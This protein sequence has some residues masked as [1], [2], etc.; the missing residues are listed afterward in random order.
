M[1][2]QV[3]KEQ[4]MIKYGRKPRKNMLKTSRN[5]SKILSLMPT[6]KIMQNTRFKVD[7]DSRPEVSPEGHTQSKKIELMFK[8]DQEN[9]KKVRF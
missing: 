7:K 2:N 6:V 8:I 5:S 1:V 4:E 9:T 3:L